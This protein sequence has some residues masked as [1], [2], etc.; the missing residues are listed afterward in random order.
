MENKDLVDGVVSKIVLIRGRRVMLDKDL[1][2]LYE[3]R[4]KD[5]NKAVKRNIERFPDDFMFRLNKKESDSLRF[6]FGTSKRGGRRYLPYVFTQEG[7]AMLSGVLNS[8]RAIR[9]N[10]QIM[11]AFV[12]IRKVISLH[13]EVYYKLAELEEKIERHDSEIVDIFEAIRQLMGLPDSKKVIKGFS[14]K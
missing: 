3:V 8:K 7:V 1:A 6:Q 13:K 5:L 10:V 4:T 14:A 12:R 9:V 11:R 2:D